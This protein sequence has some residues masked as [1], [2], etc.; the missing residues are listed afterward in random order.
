MCISYIEN[1]FIDKYAHYN[2]L[3]NDI[4]AITSRVFYILDREPNS[5]FLGL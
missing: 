2:V 3:D 5:M 4:E 1:D